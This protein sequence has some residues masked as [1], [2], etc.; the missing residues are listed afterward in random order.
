VQVLQLA[1]LHKELALPSAVSAKAS[2]L[3]LAEH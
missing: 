2:A 1:G 3:L